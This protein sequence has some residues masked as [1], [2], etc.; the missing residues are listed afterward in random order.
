[1]TMY[2]SKSKEKRETATV[3]RMALELAGI[4]V[5]ILVHSFILGN[6]SGN[7]KNIT[8]QTENVTILEEISTVEASVNISILNQYR[9][10]I[11]AAI[12]VGIFTASQFLLIVFVQ[13]KS[14]VFLF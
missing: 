1:M 13:E 7:C 3:V 12:V 5:S 2:L 6:P 14:I 8:I 11:S 9:Y 10:E 4:L